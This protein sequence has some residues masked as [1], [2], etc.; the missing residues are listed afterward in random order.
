[1][2]AFQNLFN[3]DTVCADLRD[4]PYAPLQAQ[5]RQAIKSAITDIHGD[6]EKWYGA[7]QLLPDITCQHVDL[8]VD[9][10]DIGH[11]DE[12]SDE[13]RIHIE[14]AMRLLMPWRKG[15]FNVFGVHIDSEW[16]SDYKWQR[17]RAHITD[18]RGRRVLDVGSGNGYYSLR[19]LGD[20]AAHVLS[21]DPM[22][23]FSMQFRALTA[24]FKP[25]CNLLPLRM[26]EFPMHALAAANLLVDTVFSMGVLYHRRHPTVH[27]QEL[28]SV[29]RDEGE[30]VLETL[31]IDSQDIQ[32]LTMHNGRYAKMRNVHYIPSISRLIA[33]MQSVGFRDIRVVDKNL[34]SMQEQRKTSWIS[35]QSLADFLDASDYNKTIEGHPAPLRVV[36]VARK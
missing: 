18:L 4:S 1:M 21:I 3:A 36:V 9:C 27:L 10:I 24:F 31:V 20:G 6:S 34:T 14:Q 25:P 5:F 15:P 17:V 29:L 32:L 19:M 28:H 13:Q 30:L 8:S 26:E 33:D 2:S 11:A 35:G 7:L 23:L 12:A 22:R 16:R